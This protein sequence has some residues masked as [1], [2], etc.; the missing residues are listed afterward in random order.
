MEHVRAGVT[1]GDGIHV[2]R[3]HLIGS[4][5]KTV[6]G[7]LEDAQQSRAVALRRD[8]RDSTIHFQSP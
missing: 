2:E 8:A 1:V 5:L 3:V 7:G 4:A 6:G